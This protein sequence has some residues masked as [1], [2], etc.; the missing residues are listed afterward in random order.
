MTSPAPTN[1]PGIIDLVAV[2]TLQT[3]HLGV[4]REEMDGV[5]PTGCLCWEN[6]LAREVFANDR[7]QW[8]TGFFRFW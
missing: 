2:C 5:V 8:Y 6:A 7:E 4:G 3:P 1:D